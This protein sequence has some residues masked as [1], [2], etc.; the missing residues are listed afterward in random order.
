MTTS[1]IY[2]KSY[3]DNFEISCPNSQFIQK[4]DF[5]SEENRIKGMDI[6]CSDGQTELYGGSP[7]RNPNTMVTFGCPEYGFENIDVYTLQDTARIAGGISG[8]GIYCSDPQ[9][10]GIVPGD[11]NYSNYYTTTS[12]DPLAHENTFQ[13]NTG[14][15]IIGFSG[16]YQDDVLKSLRVICDDHTNNTMPVGD[17]IIHPGVPTHTPTPTPTLTPAPLPTPNRPY[18]THPTDPNWRIYHTWWFW[19]IVI[20][21][22]LLLIAGLAG[23]QKTLPAGPINDIS[24]L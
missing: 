12:F 11:A 24:K 4:V 8:V 13:C 17:V 2:G 20:I 10:S 6:Y 18:V 21:L 3:A 19:G 22:I 14:H 15:K 5:L 1:P 7:K 9:Y 23:Y 16:S